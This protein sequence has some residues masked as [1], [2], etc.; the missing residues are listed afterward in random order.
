MIT[1]GIPR[2]LSDNEVCMEIEPIAHRNAPAPK[3]RISY[4]FLTSL[5][6]AV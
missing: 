4:R 2:S 5:I 6:V 1:K 3:S